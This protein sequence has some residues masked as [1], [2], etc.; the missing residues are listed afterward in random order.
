MDRRKLIALLG[1]TALAGPPEVRAGAGTD[2]SHQ[3]LA[4]HT[5]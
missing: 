1:G 2:L 5:T 3:C 4:G